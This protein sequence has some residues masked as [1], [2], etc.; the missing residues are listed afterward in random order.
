[1]SCAFKRFM[2]MGKISGV[3]ADI[4]VYAAAYGVAFIL[5]AAIYDGVVK[6]IPANIACWTIGL[7]LVIC[8]IIFAAKGKGV[9]FFLKQISGGVL[10]I[11]QLVLIYCAMLF[12]ALHESY[13]MYMTSGEDLAIT[14]AIIIQLAILVV[15]FLKRL[16]REK[17]Q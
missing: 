1:M 5:G 12:I 3:L 8:T 7:L 9:T 11:L 4:A 15:V 10:D 13:V 14:I 6:T 17:F 2:R 16:I